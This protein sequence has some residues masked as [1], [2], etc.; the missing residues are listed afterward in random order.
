MATPDDINEL[1]AKLDEERGAFLAGVGDLSEEAANS[2][3][4]TSMARPVGPRR[5]SS[6]TSR[7]WS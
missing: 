6:R 5:S 3:V 7:R 4:P 2:G 1:L